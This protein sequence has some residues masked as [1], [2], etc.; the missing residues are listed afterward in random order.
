MPIDGSSLIEYTKHY[1]AISF[2]VRYSY[3]KSRP[4]KLSFAAQ[5]LESCNER[6][7]DHDFLFGQID[8]AMHLQ[9]CYK[10]FLFKMTRGFHHRLG[11]LYDYIREEYVDHSNLHL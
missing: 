11:I 7:Q 2:N 8:G 9:I 10:E 1:S 6:G 3:H 5:P 4:G